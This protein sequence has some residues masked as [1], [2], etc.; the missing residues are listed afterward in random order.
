MDEQC[1]VCGS[2]IGGGCPESSPYERAVYT[3]RHAEDS[4]PDEV[5][6]AQDFID[7]YENPDY[8]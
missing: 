7:K 3:V 2:I 5:K 1:L 8:N 4:T 6:K